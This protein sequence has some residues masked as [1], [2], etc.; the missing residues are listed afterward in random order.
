MASEDFIVK[1]FIASPGGL[2]DERVLVKTVLEQIAQSLPVDS[3]ITF[4]VL[5][6]EQ[7]VG[8]YG[9]PQEQM[10][11][12][13]HVFIGL[14]A[15]RWGSPTGTH[16]SGFGEEYGEAVARREASE[17]GYPRIYLFVKQNVP[18]HDSPLEQ[19]QAVRRFVDGVKE[20]RE[21][22]VNH[23]DGLEDLGVH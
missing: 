23:F 16:D 17:D 10:A 7:E 3:N 19:L 4:R 20:R 21:T 5:G 22:L 9:R 1:V 15:D 2:D 18:L 11:R 6:W 14:L 13:C 8:E 12:V